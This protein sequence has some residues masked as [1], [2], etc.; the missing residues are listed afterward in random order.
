MKIGFVSAILDGWT[1]EEMMETAA[2]MGY[3]CVEAAC[4]PDGKAERRYA[5]VS[6]IDVDN[7]SHGYVEHIKEISSRTGV[8]ISALAYYPNTMDSNLEKREAAIAHLKKVICFSQKLG[9]GLV[10]TFIGREQTK[11]VEENLETFRQVWPPII[12]YAEEH[13]VKI[14]VENCPML[15]GPEQ[16]PGGQNLFTTPALWRT[17]FDIIPSRNFGINYDPSHFVWQMIDYI[18]PIYEFSDR[19]FHVHYK[20]IKVYPWKLARVGTMAYPLEYMAPKLPGLGDV[21][22]GRYVSALTDIGY[23]GFTCVEVEDRAFETDRERIL[24]SLRLSKRY[25]EQFVK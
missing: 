25:I 9:V 8:A 5:G 4:W 18:Q 6:H 23:D 24:D 20:D 22:W 16:W 19:I 7:T 13:D 12:R 15:F 11:S 21:D 3:Q 17:L 1:F 10:T 2:G 14:A